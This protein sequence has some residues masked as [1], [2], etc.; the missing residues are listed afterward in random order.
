MWYVNN[1]GV[2]RISRERDSFFAL[3]KNADKMLYKQYITVD[4]S[5]M[6]LYTVCNKK[7]SIP[8]E[9]YI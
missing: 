3:V 2:K 1:N 7:N 4:N 9:G 5:Y 8:K 6:L